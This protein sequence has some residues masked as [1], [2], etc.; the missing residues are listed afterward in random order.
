M[1]VISVPKHGDILY[2]NI[3]KQTVPEYFEI[4]KNNIINNIFLKEDYK[5]I[6]YSE[7]N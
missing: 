2:H 7:V 4:N 3:K 1:I 5:T 6:Y